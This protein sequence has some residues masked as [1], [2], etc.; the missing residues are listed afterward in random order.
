MPA[1][2]EV[3]APGTTTTGIPSDTRPSPTSTA[4]P[5]ERARTLAAAPGRYTLDVT[6]SAR[7]DLGEQPTN[8]Q[9]TLTVDPARGEDQHS[10]LEAGQNGSTEQTVRFGRDAIQLVQLKIGGGGFVKEFRPVRPVTLLP[11]PPTVGRTWSWT[12]VSTDGQTTAALEAKVVRTETVVVGGEKVPSTVIDSTLRLTGD[13]TA[14]TVMTTWYADR[15]NLTVKEH[16]VTDGEVQGYTFHSE[17]T[18]TMRSTKP[19]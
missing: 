7:S 10:T 15:Q 18:M 1:V 2:T 8:G 13:I 9:A 16:G 12:I 17:T 3:P 6:G 4:P 19:A 5:G 11:Q 14:T